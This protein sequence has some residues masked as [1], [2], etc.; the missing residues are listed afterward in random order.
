M[1]PSRVVIIILVVLNS[2]VLSAKDVPASAIVLSGYENRD[3]LEE[4]IGES[5]LHQIEGLWYNPEEMMLVML[6]KNEEQDTKTIYPYRVVIVET[7]DF[8]LYPGTVAGYLRETADKSKYKMMIYMHQ[9]GSSLINPMKCIGTLSRDRKTL[10]FKEDKLN[11]KIR[12]NLARFLPTMFKGISII[13]EIN[14]EEEPKGCRKV[15]P[16]D[17]VDNIAIDKIVYL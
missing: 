11:V 16:P 13:P 6:E 5:V 1:I 15:Y 3:E 8:D 9:N 2:T 14:K 10:T 17:D 4:R 7:E 12:I